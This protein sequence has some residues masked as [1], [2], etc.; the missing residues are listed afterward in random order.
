PVVVPDE[1][2]R[3][4]VVLGDDAVQ[5]AHLAL[6]PPGG[7]AERGQARDGGPVGVEP[8]LQ[9]G[10]PVRGR[11]GEQVHHA[12]RVGVVVGG[13]QREPV[14]VGEQL[15]GP[16]VERADVDVGRGAL[17]RGAVVGRHPDT[18]VTI[19][20]AASRS[21]RSGQVVTPMTAQAA[22]PAPSAAV[23]AGGG[24]RPE[25]GGVAAP[26]PSGREPSSIPAIRT[27]TAAMTTRI[28][29][30]AAVT[31]QPSPVANPARTMATSLANSV[32]GGNPSRASSPAPSAKASI[33]A[34][35]PRP[36]TASMRLVPRACWTRPAARNDTALASPWPRMCSSTAAMARRVPIAVP[37]ASRPMCSML[38]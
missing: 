27:E 28:R 38:E 11:G 6:E 4:R 10:A 32:N 5:V 15:G 29:T 22:R 31:A 3:Q 37:R 25:A 1:A 12:N 20:V 36:R 35:T 7:E 18:P 8:D 17:G 2:P 14:A 30:R 9:L 34:R 19:V 26:G 21:G 23:S 16:P 13:D 33:G 24:R